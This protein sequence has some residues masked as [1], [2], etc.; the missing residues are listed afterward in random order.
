VH[1][2][3]R[4]PFPIS[5]PGVRVHEV[6]GSGVGDMLAQAEEFAQRGRA[7]FEQ[8][9]GPGAEVK[10]IGYEW[11]TIPIL[12]QLHTSRNV[13]PM[14][15]LHSLERQRSD[16]TSEIS[17]RIEALEVSGLQM[18]RTLLVHEAGT[19]EVARQLVPECL[20]R[21]TQAHT[22]FPREKFE[23]DL[24]PGAIKARYQIGPIDPTILYIGDLSER[25][26]PDIVIKA[27]PAV[28]R[29]L[30]QARLAIVGDGTMFWPLRVY[31]RYLLLEH[32]VRLTGSIQDAPL[33]ELVRACDL[34]VV[35]SREST[36]WWPILAAW[37]AGKPV[38]ASHQAA[39]GLL[40]HQKDAVL[41]YPSENSCVWGIE[42]ILYDPGLGATLVENGK[43]KLEERFGWSALAAQVEEL[44][45]VAPAR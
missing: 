11:P 17:K 15:S 24:D 43:K 32:A 25:Y 1:L 31:A 18:A 14:L 22:P 4:H 12:Q 23:L 34:V 30:K 9:F 39:P 8:Q 5:A 41:I 35:P 13:E 3:V 20:G 10:V 19:G 6:G 27:M 2:F 28:L 33:F 42:R 16:M 21:T 7:A 40:E 44:A 26:G 45:G 36:P 38:V 37:A 29:H